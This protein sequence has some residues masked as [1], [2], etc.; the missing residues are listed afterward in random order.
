MYSPYRT[1]FVRAMLRL[2]G[3]RAELGIVDDQTGC[4]TAAADIAGAITT[5][6]DR[7]AQPGFSAWGTYHYCGADITT[8]YG[9]A[10][11]I[12]ALTRA[13]GLKGPRLMP[14]DTASYPTPAKR[15]AYSVLA[16]DEILETFG[17]VPR[18]LD[19]SLAACLETLLA[20]AP[21]VPDR[22]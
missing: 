5:V 2:A 15:P 17:I 7:I 10:E 11:R 16:T 22:V 4:P 9:F 18:P 3:E 6:L 19:E 8:W 14:I 1:N 21:T 20:P 12:F 13:R